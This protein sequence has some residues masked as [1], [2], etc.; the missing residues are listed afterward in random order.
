MKADDRQPAR[1]PAGKE[2][3][4]ENDKKT[5]A[6]DP[7]QRQPEPYVR[8]Q[9]ANLAFLPA[10]SATLVH[11]RVEIHFGTDAVLSRAPIVPSNEKAS[12]LVFSAQVAPNYSNVRMNDQLER[13]GSVGVSIAYLI[14]AKQMIGLGVELSK[15]AY[16][17]DGGDY[18]PP[19]GFWTR[20]IA[21]TETFGSCT[22]LEI[23]LSFTR[24]F[25]PLHLPGGFA[26]VGLASYLMLRENYYYH[27]EQSDPD[28]I[29]WWRTKNDNQHWLSV[30]NLAGGF[31]Y[32]VGAKYA[33]SLGPFLNIPLGGVGHGEVK[34]YSLG[35]KLGMDFRP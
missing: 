8:S 31:S 27:Y 21:P 33:L 26:Q 11:H 19:Y 29:R 23:P 7:G 30:V 5:K 17:A 12:R 22:I 32:P 6:D 14:G 18:K 1:P 15:K 24:R 28:L 10:K 13:G 34:L 20:R 3:V 9:I 4:A 35:I 25:G 2:T 16:L